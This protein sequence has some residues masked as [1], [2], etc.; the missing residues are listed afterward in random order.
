MKSYTVDVKLRVFEDGDTF[1]SFPEGREKD[2]QTI[3]GHSI[4]KG[5][6]DAILKL[7]KDLPVEIELPAGDP[8]TARPHWIDMKGDTLHICVAV[9][10]PKT[11]ASLYTSGS[12][13]YLE[14]SRTSD[15]VDKYLTRLRDERLPLQLV[16]VSSSED[17]HRYEIRGMAL[18]AKTIDCLPARSGLAT[19][20]T[21][22]VQRCP[23][24]FDR[25]PHVSF[26]RGYRIT[27]DYNWISWEQVTLCRVVRVTTA[28]T[29]LP[30]L[31]EMMWLHSHDYDAHH[32]ATRLIDA[33]LDGAK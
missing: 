9:S 6:K 23:S 28:P 31:T 10:D 8:R 26:Y 29:Q 32:T 2:A 5:P 22:S 16:A 18:E 24:D 1:I 33:H 3:L 21:P 19:S 12:S 15:E 4:C 27:L 14:V 7:R 11:S 25:P 17:V 13:L 20:S 30:S